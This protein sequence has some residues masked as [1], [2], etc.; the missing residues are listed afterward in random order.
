VYRRHPTTAKQA[1]SDDAGPLAQGLRDLFLSGS[2]HKRMLN[3][4][5]IDPILRALAEPRRREILR[6]LGDL[7]MTSG[8]IAARFEVTGPAISQ[9]LGVLTGAGLVTVRREGTKRIYRAMPQRVDEV[10]A[11]LAGFWSTGLE[12]LKAEAESEERRRRDASEN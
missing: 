10:R 12:Q 1:S 11:Y 8:E 4:S 5:S 9:H 6:L 2:F 7:E 3:N